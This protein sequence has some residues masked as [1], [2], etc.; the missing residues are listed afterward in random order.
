[1]YIPKIGLT[2]IFREAL[3]NFQG[4]RLSKIYCICQKERHIF[5]PCEKPALKFHQMAIAPD[6][7][8]TEFS[9]NSLFLSGTSYQ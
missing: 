3:Q 7:L 1:M 5:R 4:E 8:A 9:K 6:L 2:H